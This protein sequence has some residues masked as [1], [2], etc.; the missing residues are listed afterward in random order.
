MAT[1]CRFDHKQATLMC[2]GLR[3]IMEVINMP[4]QE[5]LLRSLVERAM[6]I[7]LLGKA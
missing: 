3:V 5:H 2:F 1:S 7:S 4:R 6:Y